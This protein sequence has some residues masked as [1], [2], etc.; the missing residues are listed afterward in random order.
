RAEAAQAR[1]DGA[2]AK[3]DADAASARARA[4][5]A[6]YAADAAHARAELAQIRTQAA[7]DREAA[8][9]ARRLAP[10]P[11]EIRESRREFSL[12]RTAIEQLGPPLVPLAGGILA[13][14]TA[15]AGLGPA[16]ILAFKGI[17]AEMKAGTP[18]GQQ[19][20]AGLR[21]LKSTLTDLEK[22]ASRG[23]LTGFEQ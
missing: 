15:F 9:A 10:A 2:K 4:D 1:A 12:L 23:V 20:N 16:G 5:A 6:R 19:Y 14:T 8:A 3:A 21:T 18:I 13:M 7:R 11:S 22:T 17:Q